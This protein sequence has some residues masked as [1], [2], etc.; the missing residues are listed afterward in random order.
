MDLRDVTGRELRDVLNKRE[1]TACGVDGWRLDELKAL[2]DELLD[3]FATLFNLVE[4]RGE[5]PRADDVDR[6]DAAG[7]DEIAVCMVALDFAKCF[8]RVPQGIVLSLA[9][10][11]GL[12]ERILR[13]LRAMYRGMKRPF[14]LS[15][16]VGSEFEVTNG[17][18]QGCP[19]LVIL[20]NALLSVVLRAVSVRVPEVSS[21]S[22]ADDATLLAAAEAE[23]QRAVDIV[24]RFCALTRDAPEQVENLGDGYPCGLDAAAQAASVR[25][26]GEGGRRGHSDGDGCENP[27][28]LPGASADA[29]RDLPERRRVLR[30]GVAVVVAAAAAAAAAGAAETTVAETVAAAAALVGAAHA[31][32]VAVAVAAGN[33]A[34]AV[35]VAAWRERRPHRPEAA[36]AVPTGDT[37]QPWPE[38]ADDEVTPEAR[39][40]ASRQEAT[41]AMH[42]HGLSRSRAARTT[43]TRRSRRRRHWP[44]RPEHTA[45]T[46]PRPRWQALTRAMIL[47]LLVYR[48]PMDSDLA[49]AHCALHGSRNDRALPPALPGY[50]R[51]PHHGVPVGANEVAKIPIPFRI[52]K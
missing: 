14:K 25:Q 11:M 42:P 52:M 46:R 26:R 44:R 30:T 41:R 9:E 35:A 12:D 10:E 7:R 5:W 24:A 1:T 27:R 37:Y 45:P 18:L 21:E 2:P 19:L 3:G 36:R 23:L 4:E 38:E 43:T 34:A 33:A 6:G 22:L 16:G 39:P 50:S 17:I 13:P 49:R 51:P 40:P 29:M 31:A 28:V 20:I 15:L 8:D 32:A 47:I 48:T